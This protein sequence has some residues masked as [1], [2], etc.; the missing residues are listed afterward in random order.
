ML[1][2]LAKTAHI[3][4]VVCWM[5]ALL[6]LV[7]LCVYHAETNTRS[8]SERAVLHAQLELMQSRL[9]RL[10]T[11]PAMMLTV[12]GGLGML[13]FLE[14]FPMWLQIKLTLVIG[15]LAYH[16]Q[17]GKIVRLQA[18][19]RSPWSGAKLRIWNEV[20]TLFLVAIVTLAVFKT[21]LSWRWALVGLGA[22]AG[23]LVVAGSVYAAVRARR[24]ESAP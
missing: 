21:A 2:L 14:A 10:I 19:G 20:G 22:F 16:V 23:A 12:A 9:W 5:G 24:S 7:R 8:A 18:E 13:A 3:V 15:L 6:Y 4:G 17:C 1:F 11:V